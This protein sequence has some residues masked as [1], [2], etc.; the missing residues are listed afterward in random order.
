MRTL[1]KGSYYGK[2]KF[3]THIDGIV[4]SEYDYLVSQ[5]DWHY[6]ENPYFMYILNGD[7]YDINKKEKS[8]CQAGSFLLHNWQ[9]AHYN[10]KDSQFA[11]GFH[12]EFES[13]W[14]N[15]KKLNLDLWEGSKL[16]QNPELHV[17]IGKL[18]YEFKCNDI[19]SNIAIELLLLELCEKIENQDH[20]SNTNEPIWVPKLKELLHHSDA[21]ITLQHLSDELGIHP[22]HLSRS[23]PKYLNVSL[24]DY[25]RQLKVKHAISYLS[26]SKMNLLDI[27]HA[28]GFA[29]QSHFIRT[30]KKYIGSTPSQYRKKIA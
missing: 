13:N 24:G 18:Y 11:R 8:V 6:H 28:C 15:S 12:V 16:L 7:L 21:N 23:V 10:K 30:F 5:T 25:L 26:E 9:E 4:L 1:S 17:I 20:R 27:T 14:F 3:E 2:K 22:V 29:D 19:F